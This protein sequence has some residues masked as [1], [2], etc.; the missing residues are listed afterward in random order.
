[1]KGLQCSMTVPDVAIRILQTI[2]LSWAG[3]YGRTTKP[4]THCEELGATMLRVTEPDDSVPKQVESD[5][6]CVAAPASRC[7]SSVFLWPS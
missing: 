6:S 4:G 3:C 1:M 2:D 5:M 7:S